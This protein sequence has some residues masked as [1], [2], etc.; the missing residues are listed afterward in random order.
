[1]ETLCEKVVKNEKIYFNVDETL[2]CEN[3]N[4]KKIPVKKWVYFKSRE[5]RDYFF[6]FK[7][8]V[9]KDGKII[10]VCKLRTMKN[11][12]DKGLGEVLKNGLDKYG[13]IINDTRKKTKFG[14]FLRESGIDE[15]P[16]LI[17]NVIYKRDMKLVGVRP[18]KR[19][20]WKKHYPQE[21]KE[22]V[23]KYNPGF[24]GIQ[25][26]DISD[27]NIVEKIETYLDE[28]E[29][30]PKATD[31]KYLKRIIYNKLFKGVTSS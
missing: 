18:L 14:K 31:R 15:L 20:T 1:M 19:E 3:P 4:V 13:K 29:K 11:G 28:Y 21:L 30:N 27:K 23:L 12:A 25:Y 26:A 2:V 7:E 5:I 10:D 6:Y 17:Y 16:Q 22:R 24:G 8:A 9:G